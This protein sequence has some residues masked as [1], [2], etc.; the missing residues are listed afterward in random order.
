LASNS[1]HKRSTGSDSLTDSQGGELW[2]GTLSVGTPAKSFTVDFDTGSSDLFLPAGDCTTNCDGHQ[3]YTP[4]DSSTSKDAG[5]AFTLTYG[6]GSTVSGEQ[7]EDTVTISG[8]TATGQRLGA[9]TTY[10][11]GFEI[12]HFEADGLMG[13]GFQEIS[14]YGASPV[15]LSLASQGQT[16]AAQ[17]GFKLASSGAELFLGGVNTA[18]YTGSFTYADVL[19]PG[20]WEVV[21]DSI[22]VA[23]QTPV[24]LTTAI[25]DTGTTLVIGSTTA[26]AQFY[27]AIPGSK[28]A[29]ASVG[30]GY[31]TIPC[32]AI[33]TVSISFGG[34]AFDIS[35]EIFNLG[36]ATEG[37]SDCV[38]GIAASD[39]A[40]TFW[41]V[42]DVFL[43][44][45]YTSFEFGLLDLPLVSRVGFAALA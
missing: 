26:V 31:Y 27:S 24:A 32:N 9:A 12:S 7:Y 6:D 3:R 13:M 34:K 29:S 17:F 30:A 28:D 45:V 11:T 40:E 35:P 38:G 2:Y 44:N 5:Q 33:P 21:M 19:L 8:L 36:Q 4:S 18:M 10:S 22:A 42:G 41:I 37:S 43:Q 1:S 16:T 15:F 20:Y 14:S 23:G 39:A 25:I